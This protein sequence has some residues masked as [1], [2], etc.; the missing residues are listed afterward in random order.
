MFSLLTSLTAVF[1]VQLD[2]YDHLLMII[3][4]L[5]VFAGVFG[6]NTEDLQKESSLASAIL[7]RRILS[8][9]HFHKRKMNFF[10][11][12]VYTCI[13]KYS[14]FLL[15]L[16]NVPYVFWTQISRFYKVQLDVKFLILFLFWVI[17][18]L[19]YVLDHW[20]TCFL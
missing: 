9:L 5:H 2:Y 13:C 18:R 10:L 19:F 16:L 6:S 11:T 4:C 8:F 12:Y 3:S 7:L 15:L 14:F 20:K 17:F 1:L